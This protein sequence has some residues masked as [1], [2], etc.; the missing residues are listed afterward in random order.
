MRVRVLTTA[1]LVAVM[2]AACANHAPRVIP[3]QN[4][5]IETNKVLEFLVEAVDDDGDRL[6]FGI[7]GKPA[8]ALFEQVDNNS[9]RFRWTPN[10]ADAGPEGRGQQY[11]VTFLVSDGAATASEEIIITVVLGGEGSGAP[12]F[13]T[14]SDYTL[15][16][17][18]SATISFHI[19]VRDSDS[20]AVELRL[21]NNDPGGS[22]DTQPGSKQA[23]YSWTPSAQ[24]IAE[25]PVWSLRVGASDH[26]NAEVF[27]NITILLKGG[28]KKCQG[29]PPQ[30][31]HQPLGDQ[32]GS[33]DY[34][35]EVS[36][37]D[38]ESTIK[39]VALYWMIKGGGD[40][41]FSKQ[42]LTPAGGDLYTGSIPNPG[43]TGE[44]TAEVLYYLCAVDDDDAAGSECDLRACLPEDGRYSFTAYP[45]GSNQCEN[46]FLEGGEGNDVPGQASKV[47]FD[48][49]GQSMMEGLKICPGDSDWFRLEVPAAQYWAGALLSYVPANGRLQMD[50]FDD[51]GTTLLAAGQPDGDDI[52]V[53]SE[54]FAAP[55][56]VLL[57]VQGENGQVENRYDLLAVVDEFV[58]CQEDTFEPNDVPADAKPVSEDAYTGLTSCGEA[59]WYRVSLQEGDRLDV[60]LDFVQADGDL[61]LW[62]VDA[63]TAFNA[64][65]IS[66][67]NALACAVTETDDELAVLEAAPATADY[68]LIVYPYQQAKNSYSM[69]ITITP[70]S[71]CSDDGREGNDDPG[72]ATEVG[73]GQQLDGLA[74]CPDNEDWFWVTFFQGEHAVIDITFQHADGDL[75]MRFYDSNVTLDTLAE[76]QLATALSSDDN[77]HIEYDI[78]R[79]DFYYIRVYG[80]EGASN[81]YSLHVDV[82]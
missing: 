35:V 60:E 30:L 71:Q 39:A 31:E 14:P 58:A 16:L 61:D 2:A 12:L 63:Q 66:C 57:R 3:L 6:E 69:M 37:S 13:I 59:D 79:D 10:A 82:Q 62:I 29:T 73:A 8:A 45:A 67:D 7:Q 65:S 4:K 28:Q 18:K 19:E 33:A 46:D 55:T 23:T 50:L 48:S 81:S 42:T 44:Q 53:T 43:L 20:P 26:E 56:T 21:V 34:P 64:S 47:S 5:T 70:A 54:V 51:S 41:S 40:E 76:H 25:R 38:A 75:D 1:A 9:A 22:F 27:Q 24:Q 68:Y 36:A 11:V 80:Y 78:T 32:R 52:I 72:T 49:Q 74:I 17:N 15:D 77:E